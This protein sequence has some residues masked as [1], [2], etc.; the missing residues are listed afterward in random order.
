MTAWHA[1]LHKTR[2]VI[3][4]WGG[5]GRAV[6]KHGKHPGYYSIVT[7]AYDTRYHGRNYI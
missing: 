5:V 6:E 3:K 4:R 7:I 2:S 1:A